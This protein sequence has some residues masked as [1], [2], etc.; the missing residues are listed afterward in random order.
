MF[1][2]LEFGQNLR[3]FIPRNFLNCE[4]RE[5]LFPQSFLNIESKINITKYLSGTYIP[6]SLLCCAS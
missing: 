3:K 6:F 4:I 5:S 1:F 2:S